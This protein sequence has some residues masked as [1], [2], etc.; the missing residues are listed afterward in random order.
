MVPSGALAA[1]Q[2][3]RASVQPGA[4]SPLGGA[5]ALV[6]LAMG[7]VGGLILAGILPALGQLDLAP[8]V[9]LTALVVAA[10]AQTL[11]VY[12]RASYSISTVPVLTAGM[13]LG[14]AGGVV[15]ALASGLAHAL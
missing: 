1:R 6:G 10:R 8:L 15:V 5:T 14:V 9:L 11:P 13:L 12:G 4:T 3:V 2:A 7:V